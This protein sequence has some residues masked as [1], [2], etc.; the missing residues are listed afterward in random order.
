MGDNLPH[1]EGCAFGKEMRCH[2][3]KLMRS[4]SLVLIVAMCLG[5]TGCG[6]K[7]TEVKTLADELGFGYVSQFSELDLNLN[8]INS[9]ST[10]QGKLYFTA[11]FIN[12]T[13][14]R[15][16]TKLHEMDPATGAIVE[17]PVPELMNETNEYGMMVNE[18]LQTVSICP[19][20]SGYWAIL[21]H[22][23]YQMFEDTAEPMPI[24]EGES[25]IP[26]EE[27]VD[28]LYEETGEELPEEA[29]DSGEDV[30]VEA[31]AGMAGQYQ[32]DMLSAAVA[33]PITVN[34]IG[35]APAEE[36]PEGEEIPEEPMD[37][38]VLV[39]EYTEPVDEYYIM[40]MDMSGNVLKEIELTEAVQDLDYFYPN[41][42]VENSEGDLLIYSDADILIFDQNGT[43]KDRISLESGWI[44]SMTA[45]GSGT[46]LVSYYDYSDEEHSGN[47]VS[48]VENGKL[49]E[50]LNLTGISELSNMMLTPG[51]GDTVLINDGSYL[52]T[53]DVNS[54]AATKML[55]WLDS[56]INGNNL[57]GVAAADEDT[58]LVMMA[59]YGK[60]VTYEVATLR[61]TPAE[62]LP[63][64]TLL[65]LGTVY[66]DDILSRAVIDFNRNSD[67]YRVTMVDYSSYNTSEDYSAG[68]EQLERDVI[69]GNCPDIIYMNT[70]KE[71]KYI[72][73]GLL[74]DMSALMEK[75]GA[76]SMDDLM[77]GALSRFVV[78]GKLYAMPT[79]FNLETVM[80]SSKIVGDRDSW[81]LEEMTGII[82]NLNSETEISDYD[83]QSSFLSQMFEYNLDM[84]VDYGT[85]KCNFETQEFKTLL[86]A[87]SHLPTAE[88]L[89]A[90]RMT[91]QQAMENGTYM[92]T[93][94]MQ[95][96]QS[97]ELLMYGYGIYNAYNV[98][99]LYSIYTPENGF[100][101]V[102]Y[103]QSE[104]NGMTLSVSSIL[105][106]SSK[107]SHQ[108]GA[109][110]FIKTTLSDK[111]QESR[112]DFPVTVSAFDSLME[113]AMKP[114]YYI[115]ADGNEVECEEYGFIGDTEYVL[116]PVTQEQMDDFK[117][118][119]NNS[120]SCGGYD[121]DITEIISEEAAAFFAGDKSADEVAALIQNRVTIYL[122]ETS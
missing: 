50:P 25:V 12:E 79:G 105:A 117:D 54:G 82:E 84:F 112:W 93:D 26:A 62:E 106:I 7:E 30:P 41:A 28:E 36:A 18:F 88:E 32:V 60:T 95:L 17:I 47:R 100:S 57:T 69:S 37:E 31:E 9:V 76:I 42:L 24:A 2:M 109:W 10:S 97:G 5:L 39:D 34:T 27:P 59:D 99:E 4:L 35:E 116:E 74:A 89:E 83:S 33:E 98:R 85:A 111:V 73:K 14:Q 108:E 44:Q 110:E 114:S 45:T 78:D 72:A 40:K 49:S 19:D 119:I 71:D 101:M 115:D 3:K 65:S 80:A 53:V 103:P 21:N 51:V 6:E 63:E 121:E 11:D 122:G 20:G 81:T 87:A 94:S 64:R 86:E 67:T 77:T 107:S 104:G 8:W 66:L 68:M 91:V 43:R 46:V 38:G 48:R 13:T 113:E 75:D 52:Y 96:V 56:D 90:E 15:N 102:G 92:W 23:E 1:S 55:S 58:I 70:S 29:T 61:K 120:T 16:E 22:Y 118:M